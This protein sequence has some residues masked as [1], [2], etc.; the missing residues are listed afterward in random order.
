M[1]LQTDF[2]RSFPRPRLHCYLLHLPISSSGS[3]VWCCS[4]CW[5]KLTLDLPPSWQLRLLEA[6]AHWPLLVKKQWVPPMAPKGEMYV[7]YPLCPLKQLHSCQSVNRQTLIY[8]NRFSNAS[9]QQ[10]LNSALGPDSLLIVWLVWSICFGSTQRKSSENWWHHN[11]LYKSS[12]PVAGH[13]H[14]YYQGMPMGAIHFVAAFDL[15][16]F[17]QKLGALECPCNTFSTH[18]TPTLPQTFGLSAFWKSP[19][20]HPEQIGCHW[21]RPLVMELELPQVAIVCNCHRMLRFL[22]VKCCSFCPNVQHGGLTGSLIDGFWIGY[23]WNASNEQS[24]N[25]RE[26]CINS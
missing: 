10:H 1:A 24:A 6:E 23:H 20:A 2:S 15:L 16:V 3:L 13:R 26:I 22:F 18:C 14:Y 19:W 12:S 17:R 25:R 7:E 4:P 21:T 8:P 5:T 11:Y 9:T